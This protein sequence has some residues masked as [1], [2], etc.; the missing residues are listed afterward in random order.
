MSANTISDYDLKSAADYQQLIDDIESLMASPTGVEVEAV[1]RLQSRYDQAV[2]SINARLRDCD[3]LLRKGLRNEALERC[4]ADPKL[5]DLFLIVDFPE[6]DSWEET[7]RECGLTPTDLL[8][9][10]AGE[11]NDAYASEKPLAELKYQVRLHALA[12]SPLPIRISLM[13]KLA[14][15]DQNSSIWDDDLKI[16]E[17]ARHNQLAGDCQAAIKSSNMAM[18]ASLQEELQ[19]SDWVVPPAKTLLKQVSDALTV[20]RRQQAREELRTLEPELTAAFAAFDVEKGRQIRETWRKLADVAALPDSDPLIQMVTPA[21]QWLDEQDQQERTQAA[22]DA[23]VAGLTVAL[24]KG[25]NRLILEERYHALLAVGL[26]IPD[27]LKERLELRLKQLDRDKSRALQVRVAGVVLAASLLVALGIFI[28][29]N[30]R[31]RGQV[32]AQVTALRTLLDEKQLPDAEAQ[33]TKLETEY[34]RLAAAPEIQEI[35]AELTV[36][37]QKDAVRQ[38]EF[39]TLIAAARRDGVDQA[40]FK[41]IPLALEALS[42]AWDVAVYTSEKAEVKDVSK[43]V[44]ERQTNLQQFMD[45]RFTTDLAK[46][47]EQFDGL[48]DAPLD[49]LAAL[50]SLAT[51]VKEIA[52]REGITSDL[53]ETRARPLMASIDQAIQ[54]GVKMQSEARFI[55]DIN[56]SIGDRIRFFAQLDRYTTSSEFV[57]T[58]RHNDFTK[59]VKSDQPL[60]NGFQNWSTFLEAVMRRDLTTVDAV[61]ANKLRTDA[62][63]LMKDHPGFAFT[64]QLQDM[65]AYLSKSAARERGSP[66]MEQLLALKMFKVFAA[67]ELSPGQSDGKRYYFATEPVKD[68]TGSLSVK[69]YTDTEFKTTK[70]TRLASV[71]SDPKFRSP[72]MLFEAEASEILG[73]LRDTKGADWDQAFIEL[74]GKLYNSPNMDPILKV[75]LIPYTLRAAADGSSFLPKRLERIKTDIERENLNPSTNWVLPDD[76]EANQVRI[77]AETML[78]RMANDLRDIKPLLAE[79]NRQI[80]ALKRPKFDLRYVWTAWMHRDQGTNWTCTF[81]GNAPMNPRGEL[82]VLMKSNSGEVNFVRVGTIQQ[83]QASLDN[84]AELVEGRP[85]FEKKPEPATV[86]Q[87]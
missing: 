73:K 79:A 40:S 62:E 81:R 48:K 2:K 12:R 87:N 47:S 24:D 30:A 82:Y 15:L 83:G 41:S 58:S 28:V 49:N 9:S 50:K 13:R 74:L 39:N 25:A 86:S 32:K 67:R 3:Q 21:L 53:P 1:A 71:D 10:I 16:F 6:R 60:V 72:Q 44:E 52:E 55:Q 20:L 84:T 17:K 42:K 22:Y 38:V 26:G 65:V 4:D 8:V 5:L 34:P 56:A 66:V 45:E 23:A 75:Q 43:L 14:K 59:V 80:D 54:K 31:Y 61:T 18:L 70:Q 19:S 57:G 63:K 33:L 69:Y 29:S 78:K 76:A 46:Q 35:K 68:A 77:R 64:S 36:A 85:V 37:Q 11:L 7:V 51:V 27:E